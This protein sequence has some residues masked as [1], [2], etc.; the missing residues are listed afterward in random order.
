MQRSW[1]LAFTTSLIATSVAAQG[2]PTINCQLLGG[3]T[4]PDG[5]CI[6]PSSTVPH[7]DS[8]DGGSQGQPEQV[9][10]TCATDCQAARRALRTTNPR[11]NGYR[12]ITDPGRLPICNPGFRSDGTKCVPA[13]NPDGSPTCNKGFHSNGTMCIA[14][15]N[16]DGTPTCSAGFHAS[17]TMCAPNASPSGG[18]VCNRGFHSNGTMCVPG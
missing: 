1:L 5:G 10:T 3:Q 14:N 6:F 12:A 13:A 18:P 2:P 16:P 15:A 11:D 4:R 9:G 17:G 7:R 8:N